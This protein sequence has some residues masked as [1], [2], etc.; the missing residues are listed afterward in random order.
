MVCS[1]YHGFTIGLEQNWRCNDRLLTNNRPDPRNP[2]V[3]RVQF[4]V[5]ETDMILAICI[6]FLG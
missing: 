1:L 3:A 6:F 4:M 2:L 5:L